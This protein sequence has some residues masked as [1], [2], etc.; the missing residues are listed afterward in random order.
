MKRSNAIPVVKRSL[1]VATALSIALTGCGGTT[2]AGSG[3]NPALESPLVE[4]AGEGFAVSADTEAGQEQV[5]EQL[6]QVNEQ[7]VEC[8]AAEGW[9]FIPDDDTDMVFFEDVGGDGLEWGSREWTERYGFGISTQML[10]QE[11]VGPELIGY[12]DSTSGDFD[13]DYVDPNADYVESLSE[14]DREAYYRDLYGEDDGPD[15]TEDMTEE[16][17]DAAFDEWA[18]SRVVSGCYPAAEEAVY[19]AEESFYAAFGDEMDDMWEQISNDARI[20]QA[21]AEVQ[22]CVADDGLEY[23][24]IDDAVTE[25]SER[26]SA[27]E[28]RLWSSMPQPTE[29]EMALMTDAELDDL[30]RTPTELSAQDK[31]ALAEIQAD[32]IALAIAV[33]DCGGGMQEQSDLYNEIRIEYEQRFVDANRAELEEFKNA[34][35]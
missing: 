10:P 4:F 7:V 26:S 16:E 2:D 8:M 3:E 25:I 23:T 12:N 35:G 28:Q 6:R 5:A 14:P 27:I 24:T 17:M 1:I 29:D 33:Y 31:S 30:F 13:D 32:E 22:A 21:A 11:S 34:K 20:A 15:I 19:S 9:E 18:E